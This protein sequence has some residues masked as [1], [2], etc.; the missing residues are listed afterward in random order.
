M[1]KIL[2]TGLA[3]ASTVFFA[4][5]DAKDSVSETQSEKEAA[6]KLAANVPTKT[7]EIQKMNCGGCAAKVKKCLSDIEGMQIVNANPK[8]RTLQIAVTDEA[9]FDMVKVIAAIKEKTGWEATVK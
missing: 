9:K 4:G 3:L 1:L 6:P 7:L 2:I 8:D 5:C